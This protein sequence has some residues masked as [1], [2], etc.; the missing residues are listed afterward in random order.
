MSNRKMWGR[1]S[2]GTVVSLILIAIASV[3]AGQTLCF[4][5]DGVQQGR[6]EASVSMPPVRTEVASDAANQA[7]YG[8][9][10]IGLYE[11]GSFIG[12][13]AVTREQLLI[14]LDRVLRDIEDGRILVESMDA[15]LL[16]EV[17]LAQ[18]E[19]IVQLSSRI[20]VLEAE[21]HDRNKRD[22]V[23]TEQTLQITEDAN[24]LMDRLMAFAVDLEQYTRDQ[25]VLN[26]E[27]ISSAREETGVAVE[28]VRKLQAEF[29][30]IARKVQDLETRLSGL[31]GQ[32][33]TLRISHQIDIDTVSNRMSNLRTETKDS[34]SALATR[35]QSIESELTEAS[36]TQSLE[37]TIK[38]QQ[39]RISELERQLAVLKSR[40][41]AD[42]KSLS[43]SI[44]AL[45]AKLAALESN[46]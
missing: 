16:R 33:E 11:G 7:V 46:R 30:E 37:D 20:D 39:Q 5:E 27:Q 41:E 43:D 2:R 45:S 23:L 29:N 40:Y 14:I 13:V 31:S 15:Q 12:D 8:Q 44:L 34:V 26:S 18:H 28:G 35:V 3:L 9:R 6:V 25:A 24:D 38:A 10:Y 32:V 4:A 22:V 42:L 36:V 21:M 17:V 1:S 19:R